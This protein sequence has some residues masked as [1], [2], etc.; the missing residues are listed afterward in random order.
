MLRPRIA[1][2]DP[3]FRGL[4][5]VGDLGQS[6]EGLQLQGHPVNFGYLA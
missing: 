2:S 1:A 6:T 3:E 5:L 4:L